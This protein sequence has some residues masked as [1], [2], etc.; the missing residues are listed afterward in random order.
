M[1]KRTPQKFFS[2][3]L[4]LLYCVFLDAKKALISD[5]QCHKAPS[6]R[7]CCS[8]TYLYVGCKG[9]V[10]SASASLQCCISNLVEVCALNTFLNPS[11]KTRLGSED[12][13]R[14]IDVFFL[15]F[16]T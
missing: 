16:L 2:I 8:A 10:T 1:N 5:L 4:T 11:K 7:L 13:R 3:L 14:Y 15:P 12:N 6:P 9:E